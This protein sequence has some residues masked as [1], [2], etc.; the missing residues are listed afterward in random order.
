MRMSPSLL[1]RCGFSMPDRRLVAE[2]WLERLFASAIEQQ[3][4]FDARF[5]RPQ[6]EAAQQRQRAVLDAA[7]IFDADRC[8]WLVGKFQNMPGTPG[9]AVGQL[10]F[11]RLFR[12]AEPAALIARLLDNEVRQFAD[13]RQLPA[14]W[15]FPAPT[16][17]TSL[18]RHMPPAPRPDRPN[19]TA[20]FCSPPTPTCHPS[21][22]TGPPVPACILTETLSI[23]CCARVKIVPDS[24]GCNCA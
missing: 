19:R 23:A 2:E 5:Q 12:S 17:P 1:R 8:V 13:L 18:L 10:Q 22:P 14:A 6:V 16:W 21:G 20:T 11:N 4:G 9:E 7:A 24:T 3:F 15:L